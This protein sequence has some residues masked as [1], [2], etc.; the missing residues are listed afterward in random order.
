MAEEPR[1]QLQRPQNFGGEPT[2]RTMRTDAEEVLQQKKTSFLEL[3]SKDQETR[4]DKGYRPTPIRQRSRI[5]IIF[6]TAL[7]LVAIGGGFAFYTYLK[8]QSATPPP[9]QLTIPRSVIN[10]EKTT[11]LE[12]KENDRTGLLLAL[13]KIQKERVASLEYHPFVLYDVAKPKYLG[14]PKDF[15]TTLRADIPGSLY[16]NI[17]DSWNFYS[18]NGDFIFLFRV[19]NRLDTLGIMLNWEEAMPQTFGPIVGASD[20]GVREF[21][22]II[23]KNVDARITLPDQNNQTMWGYS[24]VLG[25]YLVI[26]TSESALRNTI[27]RI[28]AGPVNE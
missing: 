24:I 3:F 28:V 20:T 17:S 18:E 21:R 22:D 6:I 7:C 15:F 2:I 8:K 26:T 4:Y 12:I 13:E 14:S 1:G 11:P 9:P 16:Q 27:E 5:G 19:K 10:P 25:K 23:V